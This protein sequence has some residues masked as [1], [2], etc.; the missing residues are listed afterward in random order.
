MGRNGKAESVF[1]KMLNLISENVGKTLTSSEI[2]LG[3]KPGRNSATAYLYK[4]VKLGYVR[5]KNNKFIMDESAEYD[6]L[7][8]FQEGYNSVML[9]D[10]L[11]I[12]NGFIPPNRKRVI[13]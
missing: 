5:A 10:E 4:F 13:Y 7:K 12:A 8:P 6:I 1:T 3:N 11:K 9:M 2:L